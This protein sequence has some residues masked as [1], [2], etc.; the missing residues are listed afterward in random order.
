M[1]S[2]RGAVRSCLGTR[3]VQLDR[4]TRGVQELLGA[5]RGTRGVLTDLEARAWGAHACVLAVKSETLI[6][7]E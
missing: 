2:E 6:L 3:G 4:G 1:E 5:V 7:G